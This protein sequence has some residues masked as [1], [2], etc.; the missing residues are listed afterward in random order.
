MTRPEP[1]PTKPVKPVHRLRWGP[2]PVVEGVDLEAGCGY[3]VVREGVWHHSK[4]IAGDQGY[5]DYDRYGRLLG[6][7]LFIP[8][9]S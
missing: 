8:G 3:V 2:R 9:A 1:E 6:Y 4:P 5:A 7:E